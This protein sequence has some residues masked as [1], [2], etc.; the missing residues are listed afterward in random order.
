MTRPVCQSI[1]A[2]CRLPGAEGGFGEPEPHPVPRLRR[3]TD[4]DAGTP[5]SAGRS[6]G[7]PRYWALERFSRALAAHL[8]SC[9]SADRLAY[10]ERAMNGSSSGLLA[11]ASAEQLAQGACGRRLKLRTLS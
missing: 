1:Q 2:L 10:R 11:T 9:T 6:G 3:H 8:P 7:D 4:S 5:A